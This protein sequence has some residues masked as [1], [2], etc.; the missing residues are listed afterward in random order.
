MNI[1][2]PQPPRRPASTFTFPFQTIEDVV[3]LDDRTLGVVNDNNFP[4][5]SGRTPGQP[6]N[7][8]F[9]TIRLTDPLHADK[10]FLNSGPLDGISEQTASRRSIAQV[11]RDQ[12]SRVSPASRAA[13]RIAAA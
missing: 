4:F 5:S 2:D 7:N 6:D 3:I 9:I 11:G 10:R 12:S 8:E 1:A 13:S